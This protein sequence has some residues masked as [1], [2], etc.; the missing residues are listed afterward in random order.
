MKILNEINTMSCPIE[1]NSNTI[2]LTMHTF[3]YLVLDLL[4][5]IT[6]AEAKTTRAYFIGPSWR[7]RDI[8]QKPDNQIKINHT[9]KYLVP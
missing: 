6:K 9:N 1:I 5:V 7:D 8:R 2:E 4:C 3:C